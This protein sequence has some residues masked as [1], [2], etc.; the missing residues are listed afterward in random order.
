MGYYG[1]TVEAATGTNNTPI[2]TQV[3][4]DLGSPAGGIQDTIKGRYF[5]TMPD[6]VFYGTKP[7]EILSWTDSMIICVVPAQ[8]SGP[9]TV[10]VQAMGS[11][12]ALT[13]GF[14]YTGPKVVRV[15]SQK[16]TIQ[17]GI[18]YA[19]EGDTVLVAPGRYTGQGNTELELLGKAIIVISEA[20]PAETIIDCENSG[21][22][23]F[24]HQQE[25]LETVISG[26]R[27][28]NAGY[29]WHIL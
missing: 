20:G 9:V 4:P 26:F 25:E 6:S 12:D 18:D 7:A 19:A 16:A 11:N 5:G 27:I 13:F 1:N 21:R 17:K 14:T 24:I 2:I 8:P 29:L 22:G 23:F 15:P 10:E 28:T 3:L